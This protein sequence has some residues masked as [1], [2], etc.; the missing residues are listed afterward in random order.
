MSLNRDV[1]LLGLTNSTKGEEVRALFGLNIAGELATPSTV[2]KVSTNK[3]IGAVTTRMNAQN[4]L[5]LTATS[6][7]SLLASDG[8]LD[9]WLGNV[10]L[11]DVITIEGLDS[12]PNGLTADVLSVT[13]V[14]AASKIS[15]VNLTNQ[16][17]ERIDPV[18]FTA[19]Q[20]TF[21][22]ERFQ[23]TSAL[24]SEVETGFNVTQNTGNI[25]VKRP[26][27]VVNNAPRLGGSPT[28]ERVYDTTISYT[29]SVKSLL[30]FKQDN[31]LVQ[32]IIRVAL[33]ERDVPVSVRAVMGPNFSGYQFIGRPLFAGGAP[34]PV[35]PDGL[36]EV[37]FE[38]RGQNYA[39][40][41]SP[42]V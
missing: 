30:T 41:L 8:V 4:S 20:A 3:V 23:A 34:A 14:D 21:S 39:R 35:G 42:I 26:L 15:L 37:D 2:D 17:G 18:A 40:V 27:E 24:T 16:F 9:G 29:L 25:V 11:G 22:I 36:A 31:D 12:Y 1:N 7:N 10:A 19:Q 6:S 5:D 33:H 28:I 32:K 38:I 13:G